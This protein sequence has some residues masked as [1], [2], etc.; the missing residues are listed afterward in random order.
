[1]ILLDDILS[2]LDERRRGLVMEE[3]LGYPQ[4]L[5]TTAEPALVPRSGT[6]AAR[7]LRVVDSQV[8]EEVSA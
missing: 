6:A 5:L 8:L 1:M 3:A 7:L 2:E 4:V